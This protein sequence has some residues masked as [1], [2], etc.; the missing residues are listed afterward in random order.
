MGLFVAV[1]DAA[2][3]AVD[4]LCAVCWDVSVAGDRPAVAEDEVKNVARTR[5]FQ[6]RPLD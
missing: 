5:A 4:V 2:A 1:V 6:P 3:A